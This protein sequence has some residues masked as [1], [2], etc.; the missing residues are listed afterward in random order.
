MDINA[1]W[2]MGRLSLGWRKHLRP[3]ESGLWWHVKPGEDLMSLDADLDNRQIVRMQTLAMP[4]ADAGENWYSSSV[5]F[6]QAWNL[7]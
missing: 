2:T 3:G 6:M 1:R 7:N 4:L 5:L